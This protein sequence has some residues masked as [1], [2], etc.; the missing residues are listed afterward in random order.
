MAQSA[1]LSLSLSAPQ[2]HAGPLD[3]LALTATAT[4]ASE[5]LINPWLG[6][7]GLGVLILSGAVS[8]VREILIEEEE[9]V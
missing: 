7:I 9:Q 4:N 2:A 1:L 5:H 8:V 3:V 6:L